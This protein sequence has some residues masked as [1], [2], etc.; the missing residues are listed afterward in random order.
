MHE[1]IN[2]E[3]KNDRELL[4]IVAQAINS[5]NER[6][7]TLCRQVEEHEA[8]I[9]KDRESLFSYEVKLHDIMQSTSATAAETAKTL[10]AINK[11]LESH[12]EAITN[13]RPVSKLFWWIV[14]AIGVI[15]TSV[16]V[17]LIQNRIVIT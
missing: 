17:Y 12:T 3:A 5:L 4:I 6:T 8:M 2:F 11:I 7:G 13:Y 16:L 14:G 15:I 1:P 10:V 9:L